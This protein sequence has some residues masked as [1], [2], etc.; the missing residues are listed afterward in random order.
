VRKDTVT[1]T[2]YG[3]TD[4]YFDRGG[5][6]IK[7]VMPEGTI[8]HEY[9]PATGRKTRMDTADTPAA[10]KTDVS[11]QYDEAGR[12]W[13]VNATKLNGATLGTA[14]QKIPAS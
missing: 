11:Y 10:A 3:A 14:L 4:R 9:D 7:V 5:R 6:L 2:R 1:D 13:K 12:L 8:R